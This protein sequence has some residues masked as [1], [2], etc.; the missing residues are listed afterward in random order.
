ML[1]VMSAHEWVFVADSRRAGGALPPAVAQAGVVVVS[2]VQHAGSPA[3]AALGME[4]LADRCALLT[5]RSLPTIVAL[6]GT[7][8]Y[9]ID[10]VRT[11]LG[12]ST[13]VA[14]ADDP[15]AVAV[16]AGRPGSPRR[17]RRSAWWA[18]V[19]R[20]SGSRWPPRWAMPSTATPFSDGSAMAEHA[21]VRRLTERLASSRRHPA[22]RDGVA[23]LGARHAALRSDRG[24]LELLMGRWMAEE[25]TADQPGPPGPR[26]VPAGRRR[27]P[28]AAPRLR[29]DALGAGPLE[30]FMRDLAVEEIDVNSAASTFVFYSDGRKIA[31]GRLWASDDDLIAAYQNRLTLS[32]G[33]S[34]AR[35][36]EQSPMV[37]LQS[38]D[39]SRVVM[40]L[41]G[42]TRAGVSTHP[43]IAI[44]RFTVHQIGLDGSRRGACS[45]PGW[46]LSST[47][48]C[49]RG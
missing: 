11:F 16:I 33:V 25:I 40:V 30:P 1:P 17:L 22:G 6:H 13:V 14:I 9:G 4:R 3:A 43:R 5:M 19:E 49:E 28:P 10:E 39:G 15:W 12:V 41:G 42:Q 20:L 35:L 8:P 36:D 38:P 24:R 27:R 48:W 44:R 45:R 26:P 32:M 18:S 2:H 34:E 7:V 29:R 37:T 31:V 47:R 46:C 23:K 21:D